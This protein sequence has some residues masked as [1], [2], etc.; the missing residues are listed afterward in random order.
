MLKGEKGVPLAIPQLETV[1][2]LPKVS[3]RTRQHAP[4]GRPSQRELTS[5]IPAPEQRAAEGMRFG[6]SPSPRLTSAGP[7]SPHACA[8]TNVSLGV[9]VSRN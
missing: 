1:A 7:M 6:V 5:L 3:L 2:H 8:P 4:A 9:R